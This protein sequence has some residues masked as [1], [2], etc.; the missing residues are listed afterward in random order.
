MSLVLESIVIT[1]P[2]NLQPSVSNSLTLLAG[3]VTNAN[4][5]SPHESDLIPA[6]VITNVISNEVPTPALHAVHTSFADALA[7]S[8]I[9]RKMTT[10]SQTNSLKPKQPYVGFIKYPLPHALV[11]QS[12]HV[13]VEP[14]SFTDASKDHKWREAMNME[15]TTFLQKN[16]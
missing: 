10:R 2:A 1:L 5:V 7:P 4:H 8:N 12:C 16:T 15:F 14:T 9:S 11:A 3:D 6:I 13:S